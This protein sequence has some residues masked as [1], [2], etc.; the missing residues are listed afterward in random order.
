[1]SSL[2]TNGDALRDVTSLIWKRC[3]YMC[4]S[5]NTT[6]TILIS[7]TEQQ[8]IRMMI[9]EVKMKFITIMSQHQKL[10][11]IWRGSRLWCRVLSWRNLCSKIVKHDSQAGVRWRIFVIR[12]SGLRV[13]VIESDVWMKKCQWSAW[14]NPDN[15]FQDVNEICRRGRRI[16][17]ISVENWKIVISMTVSPRLKWKLKWLYDCVS[18]ILSWL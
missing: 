2:M 15:S 16:D 8:E 12:D 10:M 17:Y 11:Q 14:G 6:S 4:W 5:S 13:V 18:R 3:K 9:S 1:M 7:M